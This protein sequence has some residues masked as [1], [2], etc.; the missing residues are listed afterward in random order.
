MSA[1]TEFLLPHYGLLK[2]AHIGLVLL[3]GGLFALRGLGVLAGARWP[4]A[5]GPRHSSVAIDVGLL[6]AGAL[7]WWLAGFNPVVQLWL[8]V[9]LLL[10]IAYIVLGSLAL[11]RARSWPAK[12][13]AWLA[14]LAL[15]GFMVSV[16]RGHHPLGAL[17][18]YLG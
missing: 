9:K 6:S 1:I 2:Q 12:L 14:A 8:G 7:L 5:P 17:R 4:M 11:K 15:F 3:S 10:L 18:P 13:L 16:A